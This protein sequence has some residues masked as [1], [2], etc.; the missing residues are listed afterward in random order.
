M[1]LERFLIIFGEKTP[2]HY[3]FTVKPC[4]LCIVL[5]SLEFSSIKCRKHQST[6]LTRVITKLCQR[7]ILLVSAKCG[8]NCLDVF[9]ASV[10]LAAWKTLR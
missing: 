8:I 7:D 1:V 9:T 10:K 5:I 3:C 2:D 6:I 4:L